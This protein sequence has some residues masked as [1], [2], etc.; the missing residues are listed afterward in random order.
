MRVVRSTE[1]LIEHPKFVSKR[2]VSWPE[3]WIDRCNSD[4]CPPAAKMVESESGSR[5]DDRQ[6]ARKLRLV[7]LRGGWGSMSAR[8]GGGGG[9]VPSQGA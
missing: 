6:L 7:M 5:K 3:V 9:D 4:V 8:P 2:D 1:L